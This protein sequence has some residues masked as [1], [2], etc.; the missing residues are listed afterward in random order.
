M[1][2]Y[3]ISVWRNTQHY[4]IF[5]ID[6]IFPTWLPADL[7]EVVD[8]RMHYEWYFA[9]FGDNSSNGLK[10]LIGYK[11]LVLEESY[12]A[13]LIEADKR[14]IQIFLQRKKEI[15]EEL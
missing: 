15:D 4:L 7:F 2:V 9:Y 12:Y 11:E 5:S 8:P 14:A 6:E 13:D 3:G 10:L 1:N